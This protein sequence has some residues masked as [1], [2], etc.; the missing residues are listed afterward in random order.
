MSNQIKIADRFG[1]IGIA[2]GVV[3]LASAAVMSVALDKGNEKVAQLAYNINQS[4][5]MTTM[6]FGGLSLGLR[7]TIE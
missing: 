4:A 5:A 6:F 2:S 1:Y 3:T 7:T